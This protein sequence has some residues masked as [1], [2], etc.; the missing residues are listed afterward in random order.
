MSFTVKGK[1]FETCNCDVS[2]PCIWMGAATNDACDVLLAWHVTEGQKDGVDLSGLNA[3]M[4]VHTAKRMTDGNWRVALY[5][6]NRASP[7]QSEALGAV[8][9]GGAGGHLAGLGPLIGEVAGVTPA[10]ISFESDGDSLKAVVDGVLSMESTE[11]IGMDGS[12]APV[13]SN[14][15]L[16]AVAQPLTQ[17]KAGAVSYHG[18]WDAEFSGTNS[19][20]TDFA[21]DG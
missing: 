1:Y 7:E 4:A 11:M 8:F 12:H 10:A 20:V 9:S 2:C 14:P 17:A 16:G 21:Y 5:L 13:I 6:D 18:H 3:V 19:F 15:L